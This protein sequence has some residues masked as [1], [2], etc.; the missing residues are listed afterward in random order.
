MAEI[1]KFT[2]IL[3]QDYEVKRFMMGLSSL[4]TPIS[5]PEVISTS[6]GNIMKALVYLSNKHVEIKYKE[7]N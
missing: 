2:A 5:M 4:L 3:K 6:Y 1:F 7:E